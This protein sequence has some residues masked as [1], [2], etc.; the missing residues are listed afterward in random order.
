MLCA[1]HHDCIDNGTRYEGLRLSNGIVT[2]DKRGRVYEIRN[3]ETEYV[4]REIPLRALD[5][6]AGEPSAEETAGEPSASLPV[7]LAAQEGEGSVD[8]SAPSPLPL[9]VAS[10]PVALTDDWSG[11]SEDDLVAVY[12][13]GE[14]AQRHGFLQR[15]KA[16]WEYR[17]RHST[18]H[19]PASSWVEG[20][21]GLFAASRRTL[22]GMAGFWDVAV[23][24]VTSDASGLERVAPITESRSLVQRIGRSKP[25]DGAVMLEAAV[26]HL[27]EY[28]EAPSPASLAHKL[29][30]ES[31]EERERCGGTCSGCGR[32]CGRRT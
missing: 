32:E 15:C 11:A 7:A 28:G 12:E 14:D 1:A 2:W 30:V 9:P 25:A 20:A 17:R 5:T 18:G 10:P 27:A 24:Y 23:T 26:D 3:R 29:G 6:G 21:Y 22:E 8:L 31:G 19:D 16:V 4:L 13:A